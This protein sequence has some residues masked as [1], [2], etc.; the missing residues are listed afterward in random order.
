MSLIVILTGAGIS[1][2]S[3]LPT[4]RG[5]GGLW[6]GHRVED[7][8]TPEAF[9]RDPELVQRF[10]NLRRRALLESGVEPNPAHRALA[11][12]EAQWPGEVLLV[13]QNVD[14]L[15]ERAGSRNLLHMH[16]ELL[17]ALCLDCQASA[18]WRQDLGPDSSCPGCGALGSLRP[19]IVW[20]GEMPYRMDEVY[21]ALARCELFLAVGTSGQVYPGRRLRPGGQ[22]C[23]CP[24]GRAQPR[25]L[26]REQPLHRAPLRPG[27]PD[28]AGVRGRAA[29]P[30][31]SGAVE[32]I[33]KPTKS[34]AGVDPQQAISSDQAKCRRPGFRPSS[35]SA[36]SIP[37]A[38]CFHALS[39][40]GR[41][42]LLV[43]ALPSF[44]SGWSLPNGADCHA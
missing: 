6:E 15:H 8:A 29:F 37:S 21:A 26:F 13:T 20:F 40:A 14:D 42:A 5:A 41:A 35:F 4:F 24:H 18:A 17:R 19:D 31:V 25:A 38:T 23:R 44:G 16:G 34:A 1:A 28:R 3:G 32:N 11:R 43:T 2:E 36:L 27:K 12:L 39:R 7:V 9:A 22:R 33:G 30:R 10:Y